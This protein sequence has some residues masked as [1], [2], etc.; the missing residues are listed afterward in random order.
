VSEICEHAGVQ[1]G[2]FYHFFSS[3]QDL[4]LAVIDEKWAKHGTGEM[5]SILTGPL[6]PLER[7]AAYFERGM[8]EQ[9]AL[10]E[11]TGATVGCSFGNLAVELAT[12]DE[13]VR[14]R[15]SQLFDDWAA[16]LQ[17]ALDDAVAAG[18]IPEIDTGQAARAILAFIEGLGVV[19]K[20]KDDPMSVADIVP[21]AL[22]LAGVEPSEIP[23]FASPPAAPST[24]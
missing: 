6:P 14:A 1:K 23:A 15:L 9:L 24:A 16:L 22:R 7:F 2:S 11:A 19:I 5:A 12:V 3:K 17:S 8:K 4:A 20:A 18:D 10:K 13:A 21:L